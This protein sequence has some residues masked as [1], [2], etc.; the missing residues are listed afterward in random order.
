MEQDALLTPFAVR[1]D[2]GSS[3]NV[4]VPSDEIA[5]AAYIRAKLLSL[6]NDTTNVNLSSLEQ[7]IPGPAVSVLR[8][9]CDEGRFPSEKRLFSVASFA[10][11]TL[12]DEAAF[13]KIDNV[14][15]GLENRIVKS[16]RNASSL[17][18]AIWLIKSKRYTMARLRQILTSAV[19]GVNKDDVLSA[20]S[21]IRVLA[22]NDTGRAWLAGV[23]KTVR[24][25]LATNLSD[26]YNREDCARDAALEYGADKLF[27]ICLPHPQ[28]GNRPFRSHPVYV[29][30]TEDHCGA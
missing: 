4:M 6:R 23:R 29:R 5:S 3:H 25:P 2:D 12:L 22:F 15:Q 27:D 7:F 9:A 26:V 24:V 8:K 19:L 21:Y 10:R 13:A 30:S 16:I 1:R 28:G 17:D 20:P 18:E 11:L 14:S